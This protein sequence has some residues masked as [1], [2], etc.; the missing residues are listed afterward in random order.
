MTAGAGAAPGGRLPAARPFLYRAQ[1]IWTVRVA[2]F[3]ALIV[4]WEL[5]ARDVSRALFAPPSEVA[6]S[7]VT[8][9]LERRSIWG[10]L[11]ESLTTL[12][13]GLALCIAVGVP[14]GLAMGRSRTLEFVLDP[15]VTFLYVL[16]NVAF[17][18]VLVVWL[19]LG[20]ELRIALVFLSGVFPMIINTMIGVKHVDSELIDGGRSFTAS[21]WQIMR[22]IIIPASL[23]F[24]FAGLR[25]A[26][27]AA[28]VGVIV[29][30][31]TALITGVGGMIL[32]FS[33]FFQTA[34]VFVPI[35]FIMSVGVTIQWFT[36]WLQRRWTP[37][38][39]DARDDVA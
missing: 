5:A 36:A 24:M 12:F 35:L 10:P 7:F 39:Q 37:W 29:A 26:F 9:A 33:N 19:G 16:P 32:R 11:A 31:M 18:P 4:L 3:V 34:N 27:S 17:I 22:T 20:F 30:E 6:Q 28:W 38:H 8:I 25:I 1:G 13:I 2:T 21:Q 15:Y 14:V 23:P